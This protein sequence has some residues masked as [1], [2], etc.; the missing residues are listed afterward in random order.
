MKNDKSQHGGKV[1]K[2][3]MIVEAFKIV[4]SVFPFIKEAFLWRDGAEVGKPITQQNLQRRKLAV[5]ITIGS[6]VTNYF[7]VMR[8]VEDHSQAT[9]AADKLVAAQAASHPPD[10]HLIAP[11]NCI[12]PNQVFELVEH[13]VNEEIRQGL[14]VRPTKKRPPH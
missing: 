1:L 5:W 6:F 12:S 10:I 7:L 13:Q 11:N 2:L 8:V 4:S 9:Q 14:L 3:E